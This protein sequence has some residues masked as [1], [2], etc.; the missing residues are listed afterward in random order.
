M[1]IRVFVAAM[2][3]AIV[4]AGCTKAV[5][6]LAASGPFTYPSG[7]TPPLERVAILVTLTNHGTD[8]LQINPADFV[9]RDADHRIYP[10]NATATTA[11]GTLVRLSVG[12]RLETLPLPTVTLRQ[13]EVLS[14]FIVFDVP[15]GVRPVEL[16]WRQSDTDQIA[17][18]STPA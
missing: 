11:D 16:I 8:D 3:L 14:G 12:P 7:V 6:P 9:A 17:P 4:A 5:S 1:S 10:A 15:Q 2:L 13:S 18:L